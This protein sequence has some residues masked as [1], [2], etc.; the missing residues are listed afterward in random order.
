MMLQL[1]CPSSNVAFVLTKCLSDR[2]EYLKIWSFYSNII[3]ERKLEL[4]IRAPS[5]E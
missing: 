3:F 1:G 2:K 5:R 4:L